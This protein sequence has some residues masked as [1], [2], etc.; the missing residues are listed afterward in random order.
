MYSCDQIWDPEKAK[1]AISHGEDIDGFLNQSVDT[2]SKTL[3]M[4][5]LHR[6]NYSVKRAT[7]EYVTL[8]RKLNGPPSCQLPL[9]DIIRADELF[10]K[11]KKDFNQIAKTLGQ[12]VSAV[13]VEY[14]R[15]KGS[16]D[17]G[18]YT[19]L[20]QTL[21]NDFYSDYCAVC[22][23]GGE[24]IV[25]D[26]CQ[27]AYHL[28][29]LDPP[30]SKVPLGDW[31]CNECMKFSARIGR[32]RAQEE[33]KQESQAA[34]Q[35]AFSGAMSSSSGSEQDLE[36]TIGSLELDHRASV[37]DQTVPRYSYATNIYS[38]VGDG[39]ASQNNDDVIDLTTT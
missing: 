6:A 1:A 39:T 24:L 15:W 31:F 16:N 4:E 25:C 30:L 27:K 9:E 38:E 37:F 8:Y 35:L 7:Y 23:D 20:K 33:G 18:C 11:S 5:A 26:D 32:H 12:S 13:L 21:R 3:L 14:Y 36:T 2:S 28:E 10:Q 17:D 22:D 19:K 34:R 29:C